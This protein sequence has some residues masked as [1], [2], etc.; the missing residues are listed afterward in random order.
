MSRD[1]IDLLRLAYERINET[2]PETDP[3]LELFD[4]HVEIVQTGAMLDTAGVLHGHAGVRS[5]RQELLD[6]FEQI[7]WEPEAFYEANDGRVVAL[8]RATAR[9]RGSGIELDIQLGHVWMLRHGRIVRWTVHAPASGAFHEAGLPVP[10][11]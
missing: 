4:P 2:F 8:V 3:P 11:S 10:V 1:N 9:G 5:A 6:S 7:R